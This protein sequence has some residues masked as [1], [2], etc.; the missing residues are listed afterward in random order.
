MQLTH[1]SY[2]VK[3]LSLMVHWQ[4]K[5]IQNQFYSKSFVYQVMINN[6]GSYAKILSHVLLVPGNA[7]SYCFEQIFNLYV[8]TS[9]EK[10][11]RHKIHTS[12]QNTLAGCAAECV[13]Q[14]CKVKQ[15]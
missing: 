13:F 15:N 2:T 10:P 9:F 1:V 3:L 7:L 6:A 5:K 14:N 11:N 8:E 4:S 12:T